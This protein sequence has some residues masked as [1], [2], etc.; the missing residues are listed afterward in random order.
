MGNVARIVMV[1]GIAILL[2]FPAYGKS[3]ELKVTL[4]W[5]SGKLMDWLDEAW[6]I[7]TFDVDGD[8]VKDIIVPVNGNNVSVFSGVTHKEI[9][10]FQVTNDSFFSYLFN[11]VFVAQM[12][13]D[14]HEE[15]VLGAMGMLMGN[16]FVVDLTTH[17]IKMHLTSLGG[18][19]YVYDVDNDGKDEIL[20]A[21]NHVEIYSLKSD[22]P[23][24]ESANMSGD[25]V[26]MTTAEVD[27]RNVLF[28]ASVKEVSNLSD[29]TNTKYY[30]RIYEFSLPDLDM[31]LNVS[32]GERKLNTISVGDVNSDGKD[33]IVVGSGDALNESSGHITFYSLE[34]KKLWDSDVLGEA[35]ENIKIA[36]LLGNGQKY[37]I[38]AAN[39]ISIWNA[40]SKKVVWRSEAL[41]DVGEDGGLLVTKLSGNN[42]T[43]IITRAYAYSE[44]GRVYVYGVS[45]PI[46]N[47]GGNQSGNQSGGTTNP[48]NTPFSIPLI[49][50]VLIGVAAVVAILVVVILRIHRKSLQRGA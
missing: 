5:K 46:A 21:T 44:G 37:L 43:E 30:A 38:V 22:I 1:L 34:G 32:A 42:T 17:K 3:G 50:Y 49:Y 19:I 26:S 11:Y 28:V 2:S 40:T 13:D 12:D 47:P 39:D 20:L 33:E 14:P 8:G 25:A 9:E 16:V 29:I 35:I 7:A 4:E 45:A 18:C 31:L 24:A 23:I 36:D 6:G 15:L 48:N 10:R 41:Y 27:G